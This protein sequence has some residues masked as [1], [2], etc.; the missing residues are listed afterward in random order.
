MPKKNKG[1][2]VI[3]ITPPK[4][5]DFREGYFPRKF[6]YKRD[7]LELQAEVLRKGGEVKIVPGD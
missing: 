7:A 1:W 4:G 2:K 5:N 6:H 3:L